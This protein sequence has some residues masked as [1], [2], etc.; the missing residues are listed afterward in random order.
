MKEDPE[1][2]ACK[3]LDDARVASAC[4]RLP[5]LPRATFQVHEVKEI[6]KSLL[7][8]EDLHGKNSRMK[9][10]EMKKKRI[11]SK[12]ELFVIEVPSPVRASLSFSC[13]QK[14]FS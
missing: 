3:F 1:I 2:E 11:K 7:H 6:E 5:L 9:K 4:H 14:L 13:K 10:R 8:V 12:Q